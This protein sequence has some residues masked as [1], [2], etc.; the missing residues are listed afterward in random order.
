MFP[1]TVL[2]RPALKPTE[3]REGRKNV[4]GV[5]G[6]GTQGAV[7]DLTGCARKGDGERKVRGQKG[8]LTWNVLISDGSAILQNSVQGKYIPN[9]P[10]GQLR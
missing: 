1:L 9:N 6:S 3:G 2:I 8:K 5:S 10:G 4:A 7:K